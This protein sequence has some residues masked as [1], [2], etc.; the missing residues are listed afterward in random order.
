M[1]IEV[2]S[3]RTDVPEGA[4]GKGREP[5]AYFSGIST[6]RPTI[7]ANQKFS[8]ERSS[9]RTC[10]HAAGRSR[11]PL[12]T[13]QRGSTPS[14]RL[15]TLPSTRHRSGRRNCTAVRPRTFFHTISTTTSAVERSAQAFTSLLPSVA[16][17]AIDCLT[18]CA[19][20]GLTSKTSHGCRSR[21]HQ[22]ARSFWIRPW[23]TPMPGSPGCETES[24]TFLRPRWRRSVSCSSH[25][26]PGDFVPCQK[27]TIGVSYTQRSDTKTHL[28]FQNCCQ[29]ASCG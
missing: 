5:G 7:G 14:S 28:L 6:G 22:A 8:Q 11:K 13:L 3:L 24:G 15:R 26:L 25:L 23:L 27:P 18:G 16:L 2:E 20:S 1:P 4:S 19:C 17:P 21:C 29:E 9:E 12:R 10:Q